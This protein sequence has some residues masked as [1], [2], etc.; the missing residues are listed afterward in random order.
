MLKILSLL[1]F[2]IPVTAFAQY[3]PT[4]E[5]SFVKLKIKNFGFTVDG[6]FTGL[7]GSIEFDAANTGSAKFDVTISSKSINTG[8]GSRDN[9]LHKEEYFDVA[10]YPL[11]R[12]TATGITVSGGNAFTMYANFTIKNI[13]RTISFPFS[14]TATADGY[15]FKG[16]FKINRRDYGAGGSSFSMADNLLVM[17][18]VQ[19][20]KHG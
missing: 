10:K 8:I 18:S 5:G 9:H 12:L 4:D 20:K 16:E 7:A 19:A 11:I 3:I 2:I 14:A 13:A 6:T 17:L 15:R 1:P